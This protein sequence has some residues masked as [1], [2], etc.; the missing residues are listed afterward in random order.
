MQHARYVGWVERSETHPCF[1][2]GFAML[3]P[4][5]GY[6]TSL[7]DGAN[8]CAIFVEV[9]PREGA[10]GGKI[11][12]AKK[13][14]S[15]VRSIN[16]PVSR[17]NAENNMLPFFRIV[18]LFA[19]HPASIGGAYASSRT[20]SAGCDGRERHQLTRDAARGRRR[21]VVLISR[22]WD[23]VAGDD[24]RAT[25]AIKPGHRGERVI[26]RKPLRRE[27]RNVSAYLLTRVHSVLYT[28]HT[29]LRVRS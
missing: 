23:Q 10:F 1:V 14:I 25:V 27:G 16:S 28:S 3:N 7:P 5:Y 22:R 26:S 15:Q 24:L 8:Q 17:G 9:V 19:P 11:G 20:L 29:R 21:R 12:C 13:L 6:G 18:W 4:S 2:M